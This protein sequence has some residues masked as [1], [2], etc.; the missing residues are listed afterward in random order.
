MNNPDKSTFHSVFLLEQSEKLI[1]KNDPAAAIDILEPARNSFIDSY[2]YHLDL[3]EAYFQ[4]GNFQKANL[5]LNKCLTFAPSNEVAKRLLIKCYLNFSLSPPTHIPI[6]NE[7]KTQPQNLKEINDQHSTH[8][9]SVQSQNEGNGIEALENLLRA[10][11][12]NNQIPQASNNLRTLDILSSHKPLNQ[13]SNLKSNIDLDTLSEQLTNARLKPILETSEP[14][15]ISEQQLKYPDD[16]FIPTPTRQLAEIFI[17]QGAYNKA[18]KIYEQ[19][20]NIEPEN[21]EFFKIIIEGLKN[22]QNISPH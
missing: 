5:H 1:A 20:S 14:T 15:P 9:I 6:K 16:T 4:S 22:K 19:L 3:G 10:L 18:I 13:K 2:R 7:T 21:K 17:K 12:K 8:A 11:S